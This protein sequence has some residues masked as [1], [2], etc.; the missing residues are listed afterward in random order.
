MNSITLI[1]PYYRQ[2]KMLREQLDVAA[3]YLTELRVIVVDDGS[4]EPA[5]SVFRKSDT[6]KLFRIKTDIPWNRGGA[7]NLGATVA[8]TEWVLNVDLDHVLPRSA[9]DTLVHRTR[10]N[11][12]AW[13][14][15][16]R[17][18]N[19]RADETRKKDQIPSDVR[20]GRI[21]THIDSHLM[22]RERFLISPYDERY[23]GCLGGGTPFL[24]RMTMLYGKPE[25]I[26]DGVALHVYTRDVI[27]DAS[28]ST[29]SRD[30]DEYAR[31]RAVIGRN[32]APCKPLNFEWERVF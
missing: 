4:P 22:T 9:A 21:K 1:L 20:F 30:T 12:N 23:S 26:Q 25:I 16:Q 15:F 6:A 8:D 28:I 18:R 27:E 14:R 17:W 11:A 10:L 2:P 3:G 31:R 13:Y 19:G 29:L 32:A 5:A 24:D 7:R